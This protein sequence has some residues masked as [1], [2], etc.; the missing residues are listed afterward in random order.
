MSSSDV[1]TIR[2][3]GRSPAWVSRSSPGSSLR[4]ARS[5][6][7]PKSTMTYGVLTPSALATAFTVLR[8]LRCGQCGE[9]P[10]GLPPRLGVLL[11]E[12]GVHRDPAAGTQA[13]GA[14]TG[15]GQG[16]DDH[17]QVRA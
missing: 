16:P 9:Q 7:A 5:P 3:S 11:L 4:L 8:G 1:P 6:V 12:R 13:V 14:G 10:L 2:A 15:R 17:A